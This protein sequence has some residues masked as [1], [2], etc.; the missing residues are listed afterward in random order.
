MQG[1]IK[2]AAGKYLV[3]HRMDIRGFSAIHGIQCRLGSAVVAVHASPSVDLESISFSDN[4]E[5]F[6]V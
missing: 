2:W 5:R 3:G 1:N 6:K 4:T